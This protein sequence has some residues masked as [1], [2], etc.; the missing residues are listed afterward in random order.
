MNFG[1]FFAFKEPRENLE[2]GWIEMLYHGT[3]AEASLLLGL[4]G[5]T[6]FHQVSKHGMFVSC[7]MDLR[8]T[9]WAII[10]HIECVGIGCWLRVHTYSRTGVHSLSQTI[11]ISKHKLTLPAP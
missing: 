11:H 9:A 6:S 5:L 1:S 3:W 2:I 7:F 10:A 4:C 8:A